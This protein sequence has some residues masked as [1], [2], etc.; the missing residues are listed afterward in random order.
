MNS[1]TCPVLQ[2]SWKECE[3]IL[4]NMAE[5]RLAIS[6]GILE[7]KEL[8]DIL[9]FLDNIG[10]SQNGRLTEKGEEYYKNKFIL[11]DEN[12]AKAVLARAIEDH[13]PT[14]L[15]CQTLWGK[16]GSNR[17]SIHRLLLLKR[18]ITPNSKP[19]DLSSYLM[20]LNYCGILKYSKKFNRITILYNPLGKNEKTTPKR[21][22]SP[23]RP[24]SNIKALRESLRRCKGYIWWFDKHFSVKGLEPLSEEADGARITEIKVLAGI[25]N[26]INDRLKTHFSRFQEEMKSRG[27]KAEFRVICDRSL[28][29]KIHGRWIMSKICCFNVPPVDSIYQGQYDEINETNNRP[30]FEEFWHSGLDLLKNWE[31]IIEVEG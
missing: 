15:I 19:S 8:R 2:N 13:E 1:L 16:D 6:N 3:R 11:N 4:T 5:G 20:L 22:L 24:Y 10:L 25:T 29:R 27:I 18:L 17:E 30:P 9:T 28:L 31:K 14:Q 26:N 12:E 7:Q 21:F 23:E